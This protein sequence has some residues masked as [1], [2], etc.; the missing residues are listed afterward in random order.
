M[1]LPRG[2]MRGVRESEHVDSALSLQA[3]I[4]LGGGNG[5]RFI[6]LVLLLSIFY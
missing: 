5:K 6:V 3:Y 1:I 4:Q 2:G